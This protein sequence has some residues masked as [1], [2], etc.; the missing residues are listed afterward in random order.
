MEW[1]IYLAGEIHSSWRSDIISRV[2]R[3]KLPMTFTGPVTDHSASDVCGVY[4][5]GEEEK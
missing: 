3:E 2:E 5:L 4:I 1:K